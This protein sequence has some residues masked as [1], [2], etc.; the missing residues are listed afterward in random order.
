[1]A[2]GVKGHSFKHKSAT[3]APGKLDADNDGILGDFFGDS[4]RIRQITLYLVI[5]I[6]SW[7]LLFAGIICFPFWYFFL[8]FW[9]PAFCFS[10]FPCFFASRLFCFF[11]F[12]VFF[13]PSQA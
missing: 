11:A 10:A 12:L 7:G 6:I 3:A 13:S 2:K 5:S 1:M 8:G 9:F 4:E